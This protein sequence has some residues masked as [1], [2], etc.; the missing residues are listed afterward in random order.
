MFTVMLMSF[1][2]VE[3]NIVT[4]VSFLQEFSLEEKVGVQCSPGDDT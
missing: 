3:L 1:L 2:N 4:H